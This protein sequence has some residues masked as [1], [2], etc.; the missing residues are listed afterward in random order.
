MLTYLIFCLVGT[1]FGPWLRGTLSGL[2]LA[3]LVGVCAI[4]TSFFASHY[5]I[6]LA[7]FVV[8]NALFMASALKQSRTVPAMP[9]LGR[10]SY[11]LYL[12]HVAVGYP[13]VAMLS[14]VL[15]GTTSANVSAVAAATAPP[16]SRSW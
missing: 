12:Y 6:G 4:G 16:G 2:A 11:G 10:I 9:F 3:T 1:Q 5:A 14:A 7:I 13:I 8:V 15:G